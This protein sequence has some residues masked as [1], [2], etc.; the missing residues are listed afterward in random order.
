M[1]SISG[2]LYRT[3]QRGVDTMSER[4]FTFA[5]S[6]F[7]LIN[8]AVASLGAKLT[9][10]LEFTNKWFFL[11]FAIACVFVSIVGA[12]WGQSNDD[13]M[14]SVLGGFIC[15]FAMGAMI[16]PFVSLYETS[17]VIYALGLTA[18]VVFLTGL[19]GAVIPKDLSGWGTP[20]FAGLIGLI[21]ISFIAPLFGFKHTLTVLDIVGIVLFCG[22][23]MYD[24]N[25][26]RHLD[27][28]MNNAVDVA[29]NIFLN[30]ANIFI[31]IL[32]LM[33]QKK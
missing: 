21:I 16:G 27:K 8:I 14:T 10:N 20:L 26:A 28:T 5:I 32:S 4:T 11:G 9:Y 25:M 22:I 31:R 13:V 18:G 12:V 33:G 6:A 19:V 3:R 2:K 7:T 15:A 29:V 30:F 17:S 1:E 24:M 23:M